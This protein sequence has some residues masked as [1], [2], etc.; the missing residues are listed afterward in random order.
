MDNEHI[1][2]SKLTSKLQVL[3]N[4]VSLLVIKALL[5]TQQLAIGS[6]NNTDSG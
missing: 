3:H 4:N 1:T 2:P 5:R 6:G